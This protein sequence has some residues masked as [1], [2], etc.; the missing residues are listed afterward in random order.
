MTNMISIY[1]NIGFRCYRLTSSSISDGHLQH[2]WLTIAILD[3]LRFVVLNFFLELGLSTGVGPYYL[4]G[5][6]EIVF[7]REYLQ[8]LVSLIDLSHVCVDE[9]HLV[10]EWYYFLGI[11]L[12]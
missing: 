8:K 11:Y 4:L 9:S 1:S 12:A 6:P 3:S 2:C 7:K 10:V 5:S